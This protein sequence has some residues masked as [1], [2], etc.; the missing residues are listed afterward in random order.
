MTRVPIDLSTKVQILTLLVHKKNILTQ[1]VLQAVNLDS[2]ADR[3]QYKSTNTD[4]AGTQ[5][6][7]TDATRVAGR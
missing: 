6:K 2:S 1:R 4:A 5:K 3:P 7:D